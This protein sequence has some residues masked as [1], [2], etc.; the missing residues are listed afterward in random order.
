MN[1]KNKPLK[2]GFI[3]CGEFASRVHFPA[4]AGVPELKFTAFCDLD[5]GPANAA[6]QRFGASHVFQDFREMLD[7]VEL[8]AVG[9]VGPPALHT[10]AAREL[11]ARQIPFLTE[12]P[13]STSV[14]DARELTRLAATHGDC[15]QI[16]YTNRYSPAQRLAWRI[17]CSQEF[18]P[19]SDIATTHL[20]MCHMHP[21]WDLQDPVE[22][23]IYLHGVHAIDL[24][25]FF[26]GDPVEVA[27][28]VSA[29]RQL[30]DGSY[31]GSVLAYVRTADG[32]HGTIR[33]KAGAA[34]NGEKN[35][36]VSG[37]HTRVKVDDGQALTYEG[38]RDWLK[39]TMAGDPLDGVFLPEQP[40]GRFLNTGL[41]SHTY[42]P[43]FFRFEWM[44]FARAILAGT[45]LSPSI[46]EGCKT[47]FLT[48]AICRSL[49][50]GGRIVKV[51]YT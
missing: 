29:R 37:E 35:S 48:D 4:I 34:H 36:D 1:K 31:L 15:G 47:A 14:E 23:F 40:T 9:I 16:G 21:F 11:F 32:P 17:S 2:L 42:F 45:P 49:R 20:T 38:G 6:A 43:D 7:K 28:S 46:T 41:C 30:D 8:D 24:W 10:A 18:G 33:L 12:K 27:A 51:D 39:E 22:A 44:A 3:G 26:G 25:R 50:E 5:P 19:I 13:I